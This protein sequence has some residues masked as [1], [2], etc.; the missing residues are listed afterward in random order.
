M[1]NSTTFTQLN[2]NA[3]YASEV[4]SQIPYGWIDKTICGCGLTTVAIENNRNTIIAV[5]S[6]LLATNK[7]SQYP[8][9]RCGYEVLAVT[10]DV[11][12]DDILSYVMR[13]ES[14][15]QPVKILVT[16][17]SLYKVEEYIKIESFDLVIDESDRLLKFAKL[18]T[19]DKDLKSI[20]VLTRLFDI[21]YAVKERVSFISATPIPLEYMPEWITNDLDKYK[22]NWENTTK[23][24]PHLMKRAYPFQALRRELIMP[25]LNEGFARVNEIE[26][27]KAIVFINSV[28]EITKALE[29]LEYDKEDVAVI[30][31]N[32][33]RN[34]DKLREFNILKDCSNLPKLTF[35]T[36]TGFQGIDLYDTEA[37]SIVVSNSSKQFT[38]I[39]LVT[40]LKQAISRQ[41]D[42]SNVHFGKYLFIYNQTVFE[43]EE[44]ELLAKIDELQETIESALYTYNINSKSEDEKIRKG[45]EFF[46]SNSRDFASY[47]NYSEITKEFTLNKQ[48][49]N[50]D[51]YFIMEVRRQFEE[52]FDI[53]ARLDCNSV[54]FVK[55]DKIKKEYDRNDY[56]DYASHYKAKKSWESVHTNE[57]WKQLIE[58]CYKLTKKVLLNMGEAKSAVE[59]ALASDNKIGLLIVKKFNV[60]ARYSR[61]EVKSI[62]QTIYDAN[63]ISRK[64]KHSDLNEF[65]ETVDK[66]VKGEN[67]M[68]V[69]RRK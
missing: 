44:T 45:A 67:Y 68:D 49:F 57:S 47:T 24:I 13:C 58:T 9:Q 20:D 32:S 38:M 27:K 65:F 7:E 29:G 2:Y 41:R 4:L 5:P 23:A 54:K 64:A 69:I 39:D 19:T 34:S 52:G 53:R 55:I 35:I 60:G 30:A 18:K 56:S 40:D 51:K 46:A 37:L 50:A 42:T 12:S 63:G 66:K 28:S 21:A 11:K 48:I 16:Y 3:N 26:V 25:I 43:E 62:L 14:N 22:M 61:A 15:N 31:G 8:N 36:S 33:V 10:G 6:V 59:I 1:K 17:D